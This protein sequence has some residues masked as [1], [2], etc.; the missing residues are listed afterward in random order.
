VAAID[1]IHGVEPG[2]AASHHRAVPRRREEDSVVL[3]H[4]LAEWRSA[5]WRADGNLATV[6]HTHPADRC[7]DHDTDCDTSADSYAH[8]NT[9]RHTISV[10]DEHVAS[11]CNFDLDARSNYRETVAHGNGRRNPLES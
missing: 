7:V 4:R 1:S 6:R 3:P 9:N 10:G 8:V 2:R 5:G 11:D